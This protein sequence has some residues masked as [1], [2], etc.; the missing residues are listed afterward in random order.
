VLGRV[1]HH[2]KLLCGLDVTSLS[3]LT[4][5]TGESN[6]AECRVRNTQITASGR[7]WSGWSVVGHYD[8]NYCSLEPGKQGP[9]PVWPRTARSWAW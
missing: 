4:A 7:V 6:L 2:H 9:T 5:G 8:Y 1:G 3:V